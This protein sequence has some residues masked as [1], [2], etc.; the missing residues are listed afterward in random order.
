MSIIICPFSK[1][2]EKDTNRQNKISNY[3]YTS[4][5]L[6]PLLSSLNNTFLILNVIF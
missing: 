1:V 4:E 3:R 6:S 5:P 2:D